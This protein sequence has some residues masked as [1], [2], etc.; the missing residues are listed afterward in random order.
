MKTVEEILFYFA[1]KKPAIIAIRGIQEKT[2]KQFG[3]T[4]EDLLSH[5]RNEAYTFPRQ[6]AMYLC[7]E[8]TEASF[9]LIGQEF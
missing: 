1:P 8:F 5:K 6:L 4:I 2:A 7:R 9:P 3:I